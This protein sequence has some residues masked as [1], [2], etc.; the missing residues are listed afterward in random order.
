[1]W[2]TARLSPSGKIVRCTHER[3]FASVQLWPQQ[4]SCQTLLLTVAPC[5]LQASCKTAINRNG[6]HH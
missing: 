6:W 5:Q 2:L 4:C 3:N 1:M